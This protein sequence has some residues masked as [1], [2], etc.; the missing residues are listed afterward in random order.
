MT[1]VRHCS[2]GG[3]T[4]YTRVQEVIRSLRRLCLLLKLKTPRYILSCVN[5]KHTCPGG[6][7]LI[8]PSTESTDL[9]GKLG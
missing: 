7:V 6:D 3:A 5:N 4:D 8:A 1:F 9:I 2:I